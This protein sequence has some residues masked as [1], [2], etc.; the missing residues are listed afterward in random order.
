MIQF[1]DRLLD[2]LDFV[3]I[4]EHYVES[5]ILLKKKLNWT[6]ED[7]FT[8]R[9][10]ERISTKNLKKNL[11]KKEFRKLK[12]WNFGDFYFY[13]KALKKFRN[14]VKFYGKK[15]LAADV[16]KFEKFMKNLEK[17]CGFSKFSGN[18]L[19]N[20][21]NFSFSIRNSIKNQFEIKTNSIA[22]SIF[23]SND[24]KNRLCELMATPGL[25]LTDLLW[26]RHRNFLAK[27]IFICK[28]FIF[29]RNFCVFLFGITFFP[30][31]LKIFKILLFYTI[32]RI[33]RILKILRISKI[34]R[35]FKIS[36]I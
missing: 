32:L 9:Y 20:L 5:L 7:I 36:E 26:H 31:I 23:P 22:A 8:I 27:K 6:F 17:K 3:I 4:Q 11:S 19:K 15:N 1:T 28:I 35:I 10:N 29:F 2:E 21:Q 16:K 25:Q 24:R 18:F 12:I 14:S 30:R 33:L 13:S 34:L